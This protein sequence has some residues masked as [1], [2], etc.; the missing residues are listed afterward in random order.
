VT[1]EERERLIRAYHNAA[2]VRAGEKRRGR[3][4]N[5]RAESHFRSFLALVG[6]TETRWSPSPRDGCKINPNVPTISDDEARLEELSRH[7]GSDRLP[8]FILTPLRPAT[9]L[10]LR[11][12]GAPIKP[13]TYFI[14]LCSF[15]TKFGNA[16][17]GVFRFPSV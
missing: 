16:R 17:P 10:H 4:P 1:C 15:G 9:P 12:P 3:P 5:C 8:R 13:A 7:K 2:L 11:H 14:H 6:I